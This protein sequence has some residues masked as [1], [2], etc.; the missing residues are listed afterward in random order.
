[1][2]HILQ[3][4]TIDLK[5]VY[6]SAYVFKNLGVRHIQ[7]KNYK[8]LKNTRALRVHQKQRMKNL[9]DF[10]FCYNFSNSKL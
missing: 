10:R 8:S 4:L 1:M 6:V 3:G 2:D 7:G 9:F 5:R